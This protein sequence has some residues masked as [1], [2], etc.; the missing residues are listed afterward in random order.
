MSLRG[1]AGLFGHFVP[2]ESAYAQVCAS[3]SRSF[4]E[5][6]ESTY[7]ICARGQF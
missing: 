7:C 1:I 2:E 5:F 6:Q 3:E 4:V